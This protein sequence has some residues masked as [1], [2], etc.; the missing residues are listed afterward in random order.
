MKIKITADDI[1]FTATRLDNGTYN[2]VIEDTS[3][4]PADRRVETVTV[5]SDDVMGAICRLSCYDP[6][7]PSTSQALYDLAEPVI[8]HLPQNLRPIP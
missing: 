5:P 2:M 1:T 8:G 6:E 3:N 7:D 4:L